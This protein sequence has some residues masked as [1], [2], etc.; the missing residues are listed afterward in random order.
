MSTPAWV[1]VDADDPTLAAYKALERPKE[2]ILCVGP[3]LPLSGVYNEAYA[4][5][6]AEWWGIINDDV[7][8]ETA[9]WDR[10][11]IALAARDGMAV[12][13]GGHGGT[14]HFVLGADLPR[15]TG[16]LSLPGLDRIYIDTVWADI[17][18]AL[19]VL[20]HAPDVVLRHRHFSNGG[21]LFDATYRKR[22]KIEDR[23]IYEA[24][25]IH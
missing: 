18:G 14:P 12:P 7:V 11:L 2:W 9:G 15:S 13:A 8:P 19:G 1:R 20:R 17:A 4:A 3:R 22:R 25:K 6:D 16:W 24:W 10:A 21:A 5:M 23:A